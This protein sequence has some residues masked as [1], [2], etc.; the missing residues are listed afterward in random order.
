MTWGKISL[1][2]SLRIL[3]INMPKHYDK[4][5]QRFNY[6]IEPLECFVFILIENDGP[7]NICLA[8]P[9]RQ[10]GC[11]LET[12]SLMV[13]QNLNFDIDIQQVVWFSIMV[14]SITFKFATGYL[15]I[16]IYI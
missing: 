8:Y 11:M 2:V 16:H 4:K 1:T 9:K 13:I 14:G 10:E 6:N 12:K 5:K 3:K 7:Q 15:G